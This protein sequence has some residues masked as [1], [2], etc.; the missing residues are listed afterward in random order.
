M[1][2]IETKVLEIDPKSIAEKLK[3]LGA[4]EIS[5][6]KLVVDWYGPKGLTHDGDDPWFLRIRNY[7]PSG[8]KEVTWKAKSE[9]IGV[10]RKH[11]EINFT[12]SDE[13]SVGYLLEELNLEKYAH[14]EKK[15]TSWKLGTIQFDLDI[16]PGMPSFIE[17]EAESENDINEMIKKLN[18]EK[19]ETWND[20]ERTLIKGKYNLDWFN[21]RF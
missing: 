21:M 4:V 8:K 13:S 12:V 20:G 7:E 6:E 19:N 15:R 3:I 14:Q 17:I 16:Y 10:S 1:H 5:N 9:H 18:L 11:K 2:E